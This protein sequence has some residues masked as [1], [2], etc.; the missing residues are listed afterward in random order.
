QLGWMLLVSIIPA[1]I[2]G[3]FFEDI[4]EGALRSPLVVAISLIVW[5]VVLGISD[6]FSKSLK[7]EQKDKLEEMSWGQVII[8]S[9]AQAIALIPG[10]SRSGITMTAG[11][12]SKLKKDTAAEFSFLM[13]VPVIALAGLLEVW[14]LYQTGLEYITLSTLFVGFIISAVSG[15]FAIWLLMK[16]IKKWNYLPFVFYRILVG[17]LILIFLV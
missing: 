6:R 16:I 5:G 8:I 17:V 4:I 12:F 15:F 13:S 2:V 10:T 14:E 7:S 3:F 9:I 1:G 11:L